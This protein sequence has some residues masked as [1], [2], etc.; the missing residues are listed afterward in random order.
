M[1]A[2]IQDLFL[3]ARSLRKQ[4]GF[5]LLMLLTL[6]LGIGGNVAMFSAVNG[7]LLQPLP[8]P[9]SDRV[10]QLWE[11][12]PTQSRDRNTVSAADF[13]DWRS[14]S[15]TFSSMAAMTGA[16][17]NL[18][19]DGDP[20]ELR[21]LLVTE[22]YW[23][24]LRVEPAL[25]RSLVSEEFST[26][27]GAV[28]VISDGLWERRFGADP[29][30]LGRSVDIDG[31]AY[32]VVG[33]MP[34]G[35]R[36]PADPQVWLPMTFGAEPNRGGHFLRV[37]GR[38]APGVTVERARA[39]IDTIAHALAEEYPDSNTGHFAGV[40]PYQ[41][42][43]VRNSRPALLVLLGAVGLVLLLV[44]V[45]VANM[46]FA[47]GLARRREMAIRTALGAT[48]WRLALQLVIEN[49]LLVIAAAGL[50]TALAVVGLDTIEATLALDGP[51]LGAVELDRSVILFA[52]GV[53]LTAT[54]LS[55]LWPALR[56]SQANPNEALKAG[57]R[58][59][60]DFGSGRLRAALVVSEFAMAIVLLVGAGLAAR[61][62]TRLIEVDPGF[63]A[64][65]LLTAR[66]SLPDSRYAEETQRIAFADQL[67]A[68][69]RGHPQVRQVSLTWMLPFSGRDAGRII[70]IENRPEPELGEPWTAAP[71]VVEESYFATMA[72]PIVRGRAFS[73]NDRADAPSVAIVNETMA[74][75]Y[76]PDEEVIGKRFRIGGDD[77]PWREIVGV[78][79]DVRHQ[80]L[81]E[82]GRREMYLP[83]DQAAVSGFFIVARTNGD[84]SEMATTLRGAVWNVDRDQPVA[85]IETMEGLIGRSVSQ[86]RTQAHVL[87]VFA[88]MALVLAGF[89]IYGVM[90]FAV[91]QRR[92]EIGVRVALGADHRSILGLV[93]RRGMTLATAGVALG[94]IVSLAAARSMA[95]MLFEVGTYD[96]STYA[97]VTALLLTV[98][99]AATYLPARRALRLDPV[100]VLNK[101]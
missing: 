98:G 90:S 66:V 28:A 36:F 41:D 12:R 82:N 88:A 40:G 61:S 92:H 79:G 39:E 3:G 91:Q 43:I 8:Y 72:I 94:L 53:T 26:D 81:D 33:V 19:G 45:N 2:I 34:P 17:A 62:L 56:S 31:E 52:I 63:A 101:D 67:L 1:P 37:L 13:L 42:E 48:R 73:S 97:G 59:G 86:P 18:T 95:S 71:R 30:I 57:G 5:S 84:P 78:V 21:A 87:A 46:Q 64:E 51:V 6:A 54:L 69:L 22:E 4:A 96:P 11:T 89:G 60:G 38:L 15:T 25:G 80:G 44:C 29:Q 35:F 10:M 23:K 49:A 58:S 100:R 50:G 9:G 99:L 24:V 85:Q 77:A 65:R 16:A 32:S 75:Q 68:G 55:G 7:L 76:W 47:R 74:R 27:A 20:E 83:Y 70:E 14:R 93:L